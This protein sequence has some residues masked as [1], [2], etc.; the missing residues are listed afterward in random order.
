[1]SR[2]RQ[3]FHQAT[4][5][6]SPNEPL[7]KT[8]R[9]SYFSP[10]SCALGLTGWPWLTQNWTNKNMGVS[11]NVGKTLN[12]LINHHFHPFNIFGH[13]HHSVRM[14]PVSPM[15]D[16]TLQDDHLADERSLVTHS[17]FPWY[18]M[19]YLS[20]YHYII[21][22]NIQKELSLYRWCPQNCFFS[23]E[24]GTQFNSN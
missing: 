22:C 5:R 14:E 9:I 10:W 13:T 2:V 18:H 8:A 4:S 19:S 7:P 23:I 11:P 15:S 17:P 20:T 12:S 3:N 16:I 24:T 21:Y 6:T 1:M